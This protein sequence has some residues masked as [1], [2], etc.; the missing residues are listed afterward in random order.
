MSISTALLTAFSGMKA[1]SYAMANIS[2]NIA[3][4]QTPAY[5]SVDT[6][7]SDLI[8]ARTAKQTVAGSV[9]AQA[10]LTT[11]LQGTL[12]A[13]GIATNMAINGQGFFAVQQ[14]AGDEKF[15]GV[16]LY[17]RRGD[18]TL[19]KDGYLVNG[20]DLYLFG[21]NLDP[22]TG[23]VQ[24]SGPIKVNNVTLP[25]RPTT[26]I[27][28]SAN[29]PRTPATAAAAAGD[30]APY[31]VATAVVT[32]ATLAAPDPG[33]R[34]VAAQSQALLD[35][36]VPGPAL[37]I[38][39]A[40]G[41]PVSLSTRWAKVQEANPASVPPRNAI[42]NLFYAASTTPSKPSDWINAGSAFSFDG[43]GKFLPPADANV[44]AD[45]GV[46][47]AI[48]Q[49]TVDGVNA[50]DVTLNIATGGLTQLATSSNAVTTNTLGQDG[51]PAGSLKSLSV[52]AEGT[53]VGTFTNDMTANVAV[54]GVATFANPNGLKP[55]SGGS[56]EQT[57]DS[58]PPMAGLNG[59]TITGG[60]I[61]ASNS[62]V[63]GEFS[64]LIATQQAY[65]ANV[66]VMTAAQQMMSDLLNA[67][68]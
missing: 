37:T 41:N 38:Y 52:T 36:S 15:S 55:S 56:Y 12:R 26:R 64:K 50:G 23:S 1:Q 18:F 5:K 53:I 63:A 6:T 24:S 3:N 22:A 7:F 11:S 10:R 62:D 16:S 48:P 2:G 33:K 9:V 45:G 54:A 31:A 67:V 25:G 8:D 40:G 32:N 39:A 51:Y 28:Y 47:L 35:R 21:N 14:K 19:N 43:S 61:E 42:W 57:R 59:A 60:N 65:S 30:T 66:K 49:L 58:G 34:V 17:T 44:G 29:L 20:A 46:T 27:D 13:T 68:R 4:T